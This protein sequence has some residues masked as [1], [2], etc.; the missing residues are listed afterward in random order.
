MGFN[1]MSVCEWG[2]AGAHFQRAP[3]G[4]APWVTSRFSDMRLMTHS[5]MSD[6]HFCVALCFHIGIQL[7]VE[8]RAQVSGPRHSSSVPQAIAISLISLGLGGIH[9]CP[10]VCTSS[11]LGR[12]LVLV[13]IVTRC[14]KTQLHSRYSRRKGDAAGWVC[15]VPCD[16]ATEDPVLGSCFSGRSVLSSQHLESGSQYP[17]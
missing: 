11:P 13:I 3:T 10:R 14:T 12:S 16:G 9:F 17:R 15:Y 7:L 4:Q 6:S 2:V 5:S 8:S 1:I